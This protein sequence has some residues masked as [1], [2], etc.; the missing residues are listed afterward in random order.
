MAI[1]RKLPKSQYWNV[2]IKINGRAI[3][4]STK[5][6]DKRKA[7]A[8][9]IEIERQVRLL[10]ERP[11]VAR[12]FSQARVAEV[13]RLETDVSSRQADR[14]E[15]ALWNFE[16]WAGDVPLDRITHRV[17]EDYQRSRLKDAARETVDKELCY[18][19]RMLKQ[20]GLVVEK[21]KPKHGR[22]VEQRAFTRDELK[23]FFM[24]CPENFR[25]LFLLM[26]CTGA[27]PAELVPS[28]RSAH[29]ALLKTEVDYD[30]CLI[31]IR[32]AKVLP[33]RKGAIRRMRIQK[34]LVDQ[35]RQVAQ[36]HSLK[37]VFLPVYNLCRWFDDILT[38]AEIEKVDA[39]GRKVTAHSFRHTF[40]TMMAESVGHNPF[41]VK[42]ILGH[43]QITT[44]DRYC[45]PTTEAEVIDLAELLGAGVNEKPREVPEAL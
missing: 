23:R 25:V 20:N 3:T 11:A 15:Y 35:V 19:I 10:Y 44:T 31:T 4:R 43:S 30:Q 17:L 16:K 8:A 41:V 22:V 39:L 6:T 29:I 24:H 32:S 27:R 28:V 12:K 1:L 2:Q 38:A 7:Q 9:A 45:H 13:A 37:T 26:L 34:E 33:G 21:P 5:E 18:L 42:Q 36:S 40:A 14:V